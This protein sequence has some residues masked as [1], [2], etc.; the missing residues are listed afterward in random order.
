[1]EELDDYSEKWLTH[2]NRTSNDNLPKLSLRY[3]AKG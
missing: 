1:M 3:K 2:S